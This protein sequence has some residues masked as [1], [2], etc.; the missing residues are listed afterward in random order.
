MKDTGINYHPGRLTRFVRRLNWYFTVYLPP[1]R[2]VTI[3]TRNGVLTFNSKDKTTGRNLCVH[4]NHEFDEMMEYVSLLRNEGYL[5]KGKGKVVLDVGG[6]IGMSSTTFLLEEIFEKSVAFEPSPGNFR[7]LKKNIANNHLEDRLVAHNAA[8]SDREGTLDF[9]LSEKNYG[10]H[11]VRSSS[12]VQPGAFGETERRVISVKA[13]R[14]DDLS[15]SWLGISKDD[16]ELIWM[17]IQGHEARF[18]KGAEQFIRQHPGVP[19]VM[20]FWPYAIKR[21]GVTREEFMALVTSL[22]GGYFVNQSGK[23]VY[24]G[25]DSL[26]GFFDEQDDPHKGSTIVLSNKNPGHA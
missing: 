22:F 4:R 23:F 19:V 1:E 9:E 10:D 8:L 2:P 12:D 6:Y 16:I 21:S 14:F 11:R 17:D 7:L 5:D 24:K 15:D 3:N 13:C 26:G 18:L 20:E 25:M